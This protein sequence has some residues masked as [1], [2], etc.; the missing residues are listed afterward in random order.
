MIERAGVNVDPRNFLPPRQVQRLGQ[1]P[2]SVALAGHFG[3]QADEGE[4]ALA[5]GPEV[6]LQ[7]SDFAGFIVDDREQLDPWIADN[8]RQS[9][10]VDDQP[11]EP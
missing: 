7:H 5:A 2:A 9:G 10:V 3:H 6:E 1:E 8:R 11:R 4:L